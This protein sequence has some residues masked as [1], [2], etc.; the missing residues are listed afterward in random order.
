MLC[1]SKPKA[2]KAG[3]FACQNVV[4]RVLF[5]RYSIWAVGQVICATRRVFYVVLL[6]YLSI[7]SLSAV[8]IDFAV[9]AYSDADFVLMVMFVNYF[10]KSSKGR[11]LVEYQ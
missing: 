6:Y 11:V 9:M 2:D 5:S 1:W 3:S 7:L 10:L 8:C 4:I